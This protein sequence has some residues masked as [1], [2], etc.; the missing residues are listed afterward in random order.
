[1]DPMDY[2]QI[3]GVDQNADPKTIKDAYRTLAFKYHPDRNPGQADLMK[4]INEAYAVLSNPKKKQE[5]DAMRHQFGS[6][7][8]GRFRQSYSDED[9]FRGSDLNAIFEEMAKAFGFRGGDEIFRE[10][11]GPMYRSFEFRRP[12]MFGRGFVFTGGGRGGGGGGRKTSESPDSFPLFGNLGRVPRFVLKKLLGN[13]LPEIGKDLHDT[14][15]LSPEQ[16]R[17]GDSINYT[18]RRLSK[19]LV[20]KIPPGIRDGQRIRLSG[21]GE[22]GKGGAPSGD[23]YL[24]V[25]LKKSLMDR[26]KGLL[27]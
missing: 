9:I 15:K 10:F 1:M 24:K 26:I 5:Y 22:P 4:R 17:S 21:M 8:Y 27:N 18:V 25:Q 19:E 7:A 11:Y 13:A 3:L 2:Y 16:A 14:I 6:S 12:G 23:L 20:V